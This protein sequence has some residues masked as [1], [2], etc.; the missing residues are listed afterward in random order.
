[1]LIFQVPTS[2]SAWLWIGTILHSLSFG[3]SS[4]VE[5]EHQTWYY[6]TMSAYLGLLLTAC[7]TH[8]TSIYT[9]CTSDGMITDQYDKTEREKQISFLLENI[10]QNKSARSHPDTHRLRK[11]E[12]DNS[13]IEQRTNIDNTGE[14]NKM[15]TLKE[16]QTLSWKHLLPWKQCLALV[17]VM[18]LGRYMRTVNQTGNKWLDTP[19]LGDYLI[20]LDLLYLLTANDILVDAENYVD[21]RC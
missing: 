5:E 4:F 17:I 8:A 19:D 1:V 20:R 11:S 18:L 7:Y 14:Q 10:Y 16:I 15:K 3:S 12:K 21:L 13:Y 6:L 9:H 2:L